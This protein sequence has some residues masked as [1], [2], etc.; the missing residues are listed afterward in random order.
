MHRIGRKQSRLRL[1]AYFAIKSQSHFAGANN[2]SLS[3]T[4]SPAWL[5][6]LA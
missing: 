5:A 1:A 6:A 3:V 2:R 4:C